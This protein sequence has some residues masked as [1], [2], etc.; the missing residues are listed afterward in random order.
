MLPRQTSLKRGGIL[1]TR[2]NEVKSPT[3][4]ASCALS[5]EQSLSSGPSLVYTMLGQATRV[6]EALVPKD[7]SSPKHEVRCRIRSNLNPE[8]KSQTPTSST[9]GL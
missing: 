1:P 4:K 2:S 3:L 6:H 5:L 9:R 8:F 7:R